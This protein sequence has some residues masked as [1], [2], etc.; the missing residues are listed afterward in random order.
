MMPILAVI[1]VFAGPASAAE[2]APAPVALSELVSEARTRSPAILAARKRWES[3]KGEAVA[4]WAWKDPMVGL[5]RKDMPGQ[6][7]RST[8][9][10]I[11][12]E[13][14]FPGKTA[15]DAR[16]KT[17]EARIAEQAY[18]AKELE[19]LA[20]V[21]IHYHR[22]LW[23]EKGAAAL[24]RDAQTLSAVARVARARVAS[25][26][27][28]AEDALIAEARL[29]Q[30]E[31]QAYEWEQQRLIEEED[32]NAALTAPPGTRRLLA[33]YGPLPPLP[34][35][36][37]EAVA[38]ADASNPMVLATAHML[39]YA[40]L[41]G[42]QGALGWLPDFKLSYMRETFRRERAETSVGAAMSVP[43]WAWKQA[44]K[45]RA[46]S[47]HR[48]EAEAQAQAAR[49]EAYKMIHQEHVELRLHKRLAEVY[50][51]EVVPLADGALKIALKNY[52][53]GRADYEKLAEA[54]RALIEAQL[55]LYEE[56]Y[57][58]GEHWAM[59]ERAVGS[60]LAGET[61]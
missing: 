9:L 35:T 13:L 36:L 33:P 38:R 22:L 43:L 16:M 4:A 54:V 60:E 37:E 24:R 48:G 34:L 19:V 27:A 2:P 50:G 17:H 23:L 18:R 15:T 7:E 20:E 6:N 5:A 1:L 42:R 44:G 28:G 26:G 10:S 46:A 51:T 12:Q 8:S 3:A 39:R 32:L 11:E 57:H 47:A 45:T 31:S 25:G 41:T 58:Y 14:P 61:R 55:K 29:K 30:L 53:T 49:L 40:R 56:E 59:L 52:E 21:K